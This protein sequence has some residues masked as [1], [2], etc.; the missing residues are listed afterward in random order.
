MVYGPLIGGMAS[1][2]YEGLPIRPDAGMWWRIVQD[3]RVT[4]MF[5]PT[6]IRVLNRTRYI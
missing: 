2:V 6:A 4:V 3:Y 5:S 1:V